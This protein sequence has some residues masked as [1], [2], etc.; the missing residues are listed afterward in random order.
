VTAPCSCSTPSWLATTRTARTLDTLIGET[1]G[2]RHAI[3]KDR[4]PDPLDEDQYPD[5]VREMAREL[6]EIVDPA[7]EQAIAAAARELRPS[8]ASLTPEAQQDAI[9]RALRPLARLATTLAPKVAQRL[10]GS[11]RR[12][13]ASVMA[14]MGRTH[15]LPV[16]PK[17]TTADRA[18]VAHM[19]T[20]QGVF[21]RRQ[22][23]KRAKAYRELARRRLARPGPTTTDLARELQEVNTARSEAYYRMVANVFLARLRS[24]GTMVAL[25]G[26]GILSVL[27]V[28][29]NTPE[30]CDMCRLFHGNVIHLARPLRTFLDVATSDDPA[31]VRYRQPF[32]S[33]GKDKAGQY[34]YVKNRAGERVEIARVTKSAVG[35]AGGVGKYQ[36]KLTWDEI[37][38]LGL[39]VPPIHAQCACS[40]VPVGLAVPQ[41]TTPTA[42][43]A[44]PGIETLSTPRAPVVE[45]VRPVPQKPP[46]QRLT[47][48]PPVPVPP[49]PT[50][51]FVP[52][53]GDGRVRG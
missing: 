16:T 37:Y 52:I 17:L 43:E 26:N 12:F 36:I 20:V 22:Y 1:F 48:G 45:M 14:A 13:L 18:I 38:R 6:L 35:Q 29:R 50:V 11:G 34:L 44:R 33:V 42:R 10:E 32:V 9:E 8:L 30:S 25:S 40:L 31:E 53:G 24:Y 39:S 2:A 7:E 21:L 4:D 49:K 28:C 15:R 19:A 23:E 27:Y 51:E 3:A 47:E 46:A 41:T 5:L